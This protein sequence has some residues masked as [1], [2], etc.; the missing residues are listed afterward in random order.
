MMATIYRKTTK[1]QHEVET[2]ALK[3][4]PK[5]RSML[6]MV[7]G[8]RS[9]DELRRMLPPADVDVIEALSVGGF[10]EA[11]AVTAEAKAGSRESAPAPEAAPAAASAASGLP[12]FQQRR[13]QAVRA[14]TEAVGPLGEL[15]AIRIE[16]SRTPEELNAALEAAARIIANTRGRTAAAEFLQR[17]SG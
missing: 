11:I 8:K 4:A 3:L 7:D 15:P 6:I 9:D 13:R 1:G 2:R 10:I 12:D 16:G 17:F 5:F 14:L